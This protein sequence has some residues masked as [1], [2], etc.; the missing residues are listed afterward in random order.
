MSK[1]ADDLSDCTDAQLL[2]QILRR[3]DAM[4]VL[5]TRYLPLVRRWVLRLNIPSSE[6]EDACQ[7]GLIAVTDAAR[8]YSEKRGVSFAAF[9]SVCV[10]NRLVS[11]KRERET[12][13]RK[14]LDGAVTGLIPEAVADQSAQPEETA[15]RRVQLDAVKKAAAVHLT[16]RERQVLLLLMEGYRYDEIAAMTETTVKSVNNTMQRVRRKLRQYQ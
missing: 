7:E 16:A 13:K 2:T 3:D 10:K 15:L 14:A 12:D 4:R 8:R 1:K 5:L 6:R 9:V 11:F